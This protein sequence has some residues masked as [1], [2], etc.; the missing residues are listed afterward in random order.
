M[1]CE[2]DTSGVVHP[3]S[4]G[5]QQI[6]SKKMSDHH[7]DVLVRLKAALKVSTL[8]ELAEALGETLGAVK[9]WSARG[10]V[11]LAQLVTAAE[12]SGRSLDWLV[13]GIEVHPPPVGV[14]HATSPP[15]PD[16]SSRSEA[17]IDRVEMAK[18]IDTA[19]AIERTL[20][21]ALSA[22][23]IADFAAQLYRVA[24]A[25]KRAVP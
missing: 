2:T 19:K 9:S 24:M 25:G 13:R 17:G 22:D 3:V 1:Q 18:A 6:D 8:P 20:G 7:Q 11:P 12:K 21:R 4:I 16:Y 23:E 10:S 15:P 14:A 5:W